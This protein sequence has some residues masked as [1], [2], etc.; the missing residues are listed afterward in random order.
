V[1]CLKTFL[2]A[3]AAQVIFARA[4]GLKQVRASAI[5]CAALQR[6]RSSPRSAQ[7]S[8]LLR[9][10]TQNTQLLYYVI[11]CIWLITFNVSAPRP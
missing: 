1:A 6:K 7:L 8:A 2:R 9:K 4:E 5:A 3:H 11:F 10:E